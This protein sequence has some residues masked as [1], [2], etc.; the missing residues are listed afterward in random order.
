MNWQPGVTAVFRAKR[1]WQVRVKSRVQYVISLARKTSLMSTLHHSRNP[2]SL[3]G[4]SFLRGASMPVPVSDS[5]ETR[6]AMERRSLRK[7]TSAAR[8]SSMSS[9]ILVIFAASTPEAACHSQIA[10]TARTNRKAKYLV[11]RE[12]EVMRIQQKYRSGRRNSPKLALF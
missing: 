2:G 7:S 4:A 10:Q 9:P 1:D 6:F 3:S 11:Q 5:A 12:K 8:T